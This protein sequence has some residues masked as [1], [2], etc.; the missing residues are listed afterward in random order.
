ME[1]IFLPSLS[2]ARVDPAELVNRDADAEWLRGGLT[3]WLGAHDHRPGTAFCVMGE[4]GIGK[5]ILTRRVLDDLVQLHRSAALFLTVDCRPLRT[6]RDVYREIATQLVRELGVHLAGE[7]VPKALY[8]EAQIFEI[9]TRFEEVE[10]KYAHEHLLQH[11]VS[12]D[13]GGTRSLVKWMTSTFGIQLTR[14]R[15]SINALE[16]SLSVGG[17]HLRD[18]FLQLVDDLA[19]HA[20][21]RVVLYLDNVE[22]LNHEAMHRESKERVRAD[23]EALLHLGEGPLALVLNMRNYYSSILTRRI[24]KRRQ[25]RPLPESELR[26][27]IAARLQ[28]EPEARRRRLDEDPAIQAMLTKLAALAPTPLAYLLWVSYLLEEGRYDV[29]DVA[30]A[31]V[32]RLETHYTTV[33]DFIPKVAALFTDIRRSVD[34]EAVLTACDGSDSAYRQLLDWQILLPRDYWDPRD[35]H[36]DPELAF[37]I[38]RPDL[39][40]QAR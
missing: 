40:E 36:L 29:E 9:L 2:P 16:G 7:R 13:L 34:A 6:Q 25:L 18:A 20:K 8:A 12:L 19:E 10:L 35:F 5:S 24:D 1:R 26:E 14:S 31:L 28:R 22:E 27:I 39:L 30:S 32:S 21:L 23:V 17:Q 37:L 15:K 33:A 11:K 4:K 38:G 3:A